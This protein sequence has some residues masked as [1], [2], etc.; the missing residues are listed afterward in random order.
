[1]KVKILKKLVSVV[2]VVTMLMVCIPSAFAVTEDELSDGYEYGAVLVSLKYSAPSFEKLLP[3]FEITEARLI[4]PGS[5]TQNVYYVKFAEKTKEIV[6]EAISVLNES[7]YVN[8]AEPNYY[9]QVEPVD[10]PT[11]PYETTE[12]TSGVLKGDTDGDGQVS[13]EDVTFIQSH[14]VKLCNFNETQMLSADVDDD[15]IISIRDA[16]MIQKH[17]VGLIIDN[18]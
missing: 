16:T 5:A 18:W 14:L 13:I 11:D 2:L 12:P 7:P 9:R 15:G 4:T 8:I 3:G 17:L 1:M 10:E 6:W